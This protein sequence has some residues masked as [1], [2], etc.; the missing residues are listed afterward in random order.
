MYCKKILL[1][2]LLS[3]IFLTFSHS[4]FG[5]EPITKEILNDR[6]CKAIESYKNKLKYFSLK[7]K[8]KIVSKLKKDD[9]EGEIEFIFHPD[10]VIYHG[11]RK[12]YKR[13]KMEYYG[14]GLNHN[15]FFDVISND[16][17]N[18]AVKEFDFL[19]RASM[20]GQSNEAIKTKLKTFMSNKEKRTS[21]PYWIMFFDFH[22]YD[23]IEKVIQDKNFEI[24]KSETV[25]EKDKNYVKIFYQYVE[26]KPKGMQ[27]YTGHLLFDPDLAWAIKYGEENV[28]KPDGVTYYVTVSHE[29]EENKDVPL[30]KSRKDH[31]VT[32]TP[33]NKE[34]DIVNWELNYSIKLIDKPL[35]ESEFSLSHF[36][37][38]EPMGV[39]WPK[40]PT[41][42]Y[43]WL[44]RIALGLA[45][46]S[47]CF[48]L[49]NKIVKRKKKNTSI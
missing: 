1:F 45:I 31:A 18:W 13:D 35:P 27:K 48:Y 22:I 3:S 24:V 49:A 41:P 8:T 11:Q 25:K 43:I 32:S 26:K 34:E 46:L 29:Y 38:P 37:L 40:P 44:L 2:V 7:E 17:K 4:T 47:F 14:A 28:L 15:Y 36:G 10:L 42:P 30:L 33:T 20:N 16:G 5:Q 9:L 6:L 12:R 21:L 19:Q 23:T 39:T